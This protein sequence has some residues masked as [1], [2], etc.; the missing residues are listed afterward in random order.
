[1]DLARL[2]ILLYED[3]PGRE[4]LHLGRILD[5]F[6]VPWKTMEV[7]KLKE[8]ED[9][10]QDHVLFSSAQSVAAVLKQIGPAAD[11]VAR[12][13][14]FYI[15]SGDDRELS[16]RGL[17]TLS[18]NPSLLL[19]QA[20]AGN[21]TFSVSR[22]LADLAGPMA[23]LEFSSE[24]RKDDNILAGTAGHEAA[25]TTI[26]SAG[27]APMFIQFQWAGI[28]IFFCASSHIIDI[29]QK[30]GPGF[31]DVKDHFCSVVPL[32]MFVK[33]MFREVGWHPQELGACL[34]I[35]DPLLRKRYGACDFG[36]LR[37]L[38]R[39]YGFTTN[40]AFIPW[41]WRR[42]SAS[43]SE[44]F[45][46]AS[47]SF[48][49]SIHGCDHIGGEFGATS[50]T[51]LNQRARLAQSRMQNH[52][53]RTG[54]HHDPVMVFPQG[55]FSTVSPEAL[56]RNGFLAAVNTETIPADHCGAGTQIKDIWDIAIMRYKS[57]PIFTRRYPHHGLENFAFDLLLGKPCLI[58]SH[59]DFFRN[60]CAALIELIEK[61]Q[62]LNCSLRWRSL[63]DVIRRA[64]RRRVNEMG[65]EEVEM[66]GSELL[67]QNQLDQVIDVRVRKKENETER[68]AEVRCDQKPINWVT[69]SEHLIYED[70]IEPCREKL[71]QVLHRQ[72]EVAEN[73]SRPLR[74]EVSVAV[75]RILSEFRDEWLSRSSFLTSA[76][77]NL[78]EMLPKAR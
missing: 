27:G 4:H 37:D 10:L 11:S 33:S 15:Y 24:L 16:E 53:V 20:P 63:G 38:M 29:D 26:V 30:L 9:R 39:R 32:V 44:F 48:S 19:Q 45:R 67:I 69:R 57:F 70:K 56:K 5:F 77:A 3:A 52:E 62:S 78:K 8:V 71:I 59:H 31:Y 60:D 35:D 28:P 14:S 73:A 12:P 58:V 43:N 49:V 42:T 74:F 7:S 25:L 6:G 47:A 55:V 72:D 1:M 76:A 18:G 68:V 75:R 65:V 50:P 34:I 64:C 40:I 36:M 13:V 46:N 23:G 2:A 54:I 66:Y 22:D 41:N 61:L 17:Q 21:L 51:A